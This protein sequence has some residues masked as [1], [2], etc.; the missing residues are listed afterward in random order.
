MLTN[1]WVKFHLTNSNSNSNSQGS[2][3]LLSTLYHPL[4]LSP[5]VLSHQRWLPGQKEQNRGT[6]VFLTLIFQNIYA[7][8]TGKPLHRKKKPVHRTGIRTFMC[9]LIS[10]MLLHL[11]TL[12]SVKLPSQRVSFLEQPFGSPLNKMEP[13]SSSVSHPARLRHLKVSGSHPIS[14]VMITK[15]RCIPF[16]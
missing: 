9:F 1:K 4:L 7:F 16:E 3:P 10:H 11:G 6:L 2:I 13:N 5:E 8:Y 14:F 15:S 12:T